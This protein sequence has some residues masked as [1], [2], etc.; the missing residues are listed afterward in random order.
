MKNRFVKIT[1]ILSMVLAIAIPTQVFAADNNCS[2][3]QS[4]NSNTNLSKIYGQIS[5]TSVNSLLK[6]VAL[7]SGGKIDMTQ[8]QN[9]LK[10][11]TAQKTTTT[12][13]AKQTTPTAPATAAAPAAPAKATTPAATAPATPAKATTP[14]TPAPAT[15]AKAATPAAPAKTTTAPAPTNTTSSTL[16]TYEQQVV[17]LVNKE[18]ASAGLSALKVNTSLANVAEKKAEDMR[19][20][21]YFSHTSPTYGSPFD[22]MK[23]FGISYTAAGEN[24]AKGQRTPQEVMTGWMNSEGH[25]ANILNSN[26]TEIGVGYVTDSN[27][28]GYWVQEFIRP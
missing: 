9:L 24:I 4:N 5:Q 22:M 8:L 16:G 23:Q 26:Y 2:L 13:T 6:T 10:Q 18:R 14:A 17:D 12:T 19:D 25:R 21:N 1:L 28:T 3:N 11:C 20:K 15:P 27:G 7:Q